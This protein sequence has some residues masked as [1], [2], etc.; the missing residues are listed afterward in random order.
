[1]FLNFWNKSGRTDVAQ[2]IVVNQTVIPLFSDML[3]FIYEALT[4]LERRK[5]T[6]AFALLRKPLKYN[7]WFATWLWADE[8]DFYARMKSSPADDMDDQKI[9][10]ERRKELL[11]TAVQSFGDGTGLDGDVLY[12]IIFERGNAVGLAPYFDMAAHLVTTNK[13][14]RTDRLNLNFIFKNPGDT[15]VYEN[16]Y[17]PLANVLMYLLVAGAYLWEDDPDIGI[18][19]TM[20]ARGYAR[21]IRVDV[22]GRDNGVVRLD[23]RGV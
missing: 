18:I 10:A 22:L 13:K 11:N 1:M 23:K 7:L 14:I 9:P 20:G 3:H 16:I 5:I 17:Y 12:Q 21:N 4:C 19:C 6:V 2:R 8:D 15:D